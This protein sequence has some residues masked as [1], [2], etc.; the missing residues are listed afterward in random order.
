VGEYHINH[1]PETQWLLKD[2][3]VAVNGMVQLPERPGFGIEFDSAKVE[4]QEVLTTL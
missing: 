1:V 2:P 4:K 3:P